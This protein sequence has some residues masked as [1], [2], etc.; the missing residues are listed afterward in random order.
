MA[1][2]EEDT[3]KP[4]RL[5]Y[6]KGDLIIKEGD[7]GVSMYKILSGTIE[8]LAESGDLEIPLAILSDGDIIGEMAFLDRN[9]Q[10]RTATARA[11]KD[12]ELEVWHPDMLEK[13][14]EEM[15]DILKLISDQ[16]LGRLNRMNRLIP[17][18]VEKR[19]KKRTPPEKKDPYASVRRHYRKKVNLPAFCRPLTAATGGR[20]SCAIRDI[21][22]GG[23][24]VE[25]RPKNPNFPYSTGHEFEVW[26]TLPNEKDV[27]FTARIE[28]RKK[29]S[30]LGSYILGMSFTLLSD[31][32]SKDLGF[33]LMP[34]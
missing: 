25:I 33:F 34:S 4:H 19:R 21:S 27:F 26:T 29:G 15:P 32:A 5:K 14:Y 1:Q 12:A 31:Q 22:M 23:A 28:N 20:M 7:Y 2:L 9:S 16:A 8:V 3:L 17:R 11:L 30:D 18:L 24:G 13:E 6:K 10:R